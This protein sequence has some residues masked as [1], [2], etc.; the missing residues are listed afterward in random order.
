[1]LLARQVFRVLQEAR[2]LDVGL[3]LLSFFQLPHHNKS[4][5]THRFQQC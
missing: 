1:M 5:F 2:L 4:L 3:T